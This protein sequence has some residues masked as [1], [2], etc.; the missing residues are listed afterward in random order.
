[1]AD[2]GKNSVFRSVP[3]KET[4]LEWLHRIQINDFDD[5]HAITETAFNFD[6]FNAILLELEPYYYPCK[7]AIYLHRPLT[8]KRALTILRQLVK[9]HGYTFLTRERLIAGNKVT[10]YWLAPEIVDCAQPLSPSQ[11]K[12]SFT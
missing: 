4:T 3:T 10:E 9:P 2:R 11:C 8:M 5:A 12:I 6:E 7:A 1:M